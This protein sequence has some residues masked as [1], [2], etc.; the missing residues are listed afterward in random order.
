MRIILYKF[1]KKSNSTARPSNN[2]TRIE[3]D[4]V[5]IK[6]PSS[7][8]APLLQL[9]K[10]KDPN[11]Y[12]YIYIPSFNRYYFVQDIT[13]GI[14]VWLVSCITDVL[15][16]F[17]EDILASNQYVLRSASNYN[18]NI[19]D[20]LYTT[21]ADFTR[22]SNNIGTPYKVGSPALTYPNMFNQTYE[23]GTFIIGVVSGNNNSGISYYA[24]SNSQFEELLASLM[25][26]VPSDMAD[27]SSGIAKSLYN[28]MQYIVSCKWL[29]EVL[30]SF[31][32]LDSSI[33]FGG[34][35]VTLTGAVNGISGA[36]LRTHLRSEVTIPKHPQANTLP[37]T[38]LA[39][40]SQ[41]ELLFEPF[42]IIPIDTTKLYDDST[43]YLDMY[44]DITTGDTEL[45]ILTSGGDLVS[46]HT[47][48]IS[49]D[50]PIIQ[51]TVDYLGAGI[52]A[53]GGITGAIGGFLSGSIG[54]AINSAVSGIGSAINSAMPQVQ[55]S[56]IPSSFLMTITSAPVL[57]GFF[58]SQVDIDNAR[59]GQPLCEIATL[60]TLSG[61]A[62]CSNAVVNYSVSAPLSIE[63]D[64]VNSLLNSGVYIE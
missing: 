45:R 8:N 47:S 54:S 35:T 57:H 53:V 17:R 3:L 9:A 30:Y 50:L 15:A 32:T 33:D 6:T 31:S 62:L 27:V 36:S 41:Y 14:G 2:T 59:Y 60:S 26:F 58:T 22:I 40:Y 7:I 43:L 49:V 4:N 48:N 38:N 63:A 25:A 56:G 28:P 51:I 61:Y 11:G 55:V 29:P 20:N 24:L 64:E 13:Y 34:Y 21:K 5:Q 23:N 18:G 12:N 46:M 19:V 44:I 39:P 10:D 16:S 42:G 52:N 1:N 37:Y